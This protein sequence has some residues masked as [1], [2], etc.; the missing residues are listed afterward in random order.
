MEG[1]L[2]EIRDLRKGRGFRVY[3][4]FDGETICIVVNAGDKSTQTRDIALSK[5]RLKTL[6]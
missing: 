2:W 5:E 3:F 6:E 4:G 1:V